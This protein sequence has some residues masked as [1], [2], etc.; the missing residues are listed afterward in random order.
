MENVRLKFI[1]GKQKKFLDEVSSK[2]ELS[3][4]A[5]SKIANVHSRS[6]RDWKREKLTMTLAAAEKFVALFSVALS[7]DKKIMVE[8]WQKT[9][10]RASRIGGFA[11]FKKHGSPATLEGRRKGGIKRIA[12]LRKNGIIPSFKIYKLPTGFSE[13]LA[14]YV[15]IMLGDGGITAGQCT[16]TL[17]SEADREY[18]YFVSLLEKELFGETPKVYK[19]KDSKALVLYYNG[20]FLIKYL[21]SIGLKTGNKVRQQV[22]AP[23]WIKNSPKYSMACIRGLMDTDGGVFLHRYRVNRKEYVYKKICFTNRSVPLLIF[24]KKTL[25]KLGFAPKLISNVANKKVWLYNTNEV[26]AYLKKVGT[27][28]PRLNNI[29]G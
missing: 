18:I 19:R 29:G 16:I 14:E 12:N 7:E 6:F 22:D 1:S 15:G 28:N 3:T 21:L 5:L 8:R 17:N 2:S 24:V 23:N 27:S 4:R 25:E 20:T 13:K 9:K 11:L 26:K 10:E